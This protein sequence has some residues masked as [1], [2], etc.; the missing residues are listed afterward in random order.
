MLDGKVHATE[1]INIAPGFA[2]TTGRQ[3]KSTLFTVYVGTDKSPY[4]LHR[5]LLTR[6]CSYFK[7]LHAF[8]GTET[9][10]NSAHLDTAVDTV[11]A[12]DMF[13]E[14]I[15]QDTY[16]APE[17]LTNPWKAL[18][19]GEVYVLAERL[20]M[21]DLKS[22]SLRYMAQT[23]ANAYGT[24]TSELY[25]SRGRA[26]RNETTPVMD[27][28]GIL[29]LLHTVYSHTSKQDSPDD[30]PDQSKMKEKDSVGESSGVEETSDEKSR[31]SSS[32]GSTAQLLPKDPM[33]HLLARYCAS[34]LTALRGMPEFMQL[35]RTQGE[36]AEDLIM[37]VAQRAERV[38]KDEVDRL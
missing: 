14:F 26:W 35:F 2:D 16:T 34:N 33:R 12:F 7:S 23:L 37:E 24:K 11:Q 20:M 3:F 1:D 25:Y 30:V 5:D 32:T 6:R 22:L 17:Y 13:V 38:T 28:G 15:Y 10:S 18:V 27:T 4:Y 9:S 31:G 36:F 19:H 8:G 29:Q 21:A